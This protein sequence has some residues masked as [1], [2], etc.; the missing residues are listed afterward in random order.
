MEGQEQA[1]G[2][3]VIPWGRGWKGEAPGRGREEARGAG[4]P[5][6]LEA[7]MCSGPAVSGLFEL[8]S[9]DSVNYGLLLA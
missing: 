9:S 4:W 6:L 3:A 2:V 5:G 1:E 8:C 7:S